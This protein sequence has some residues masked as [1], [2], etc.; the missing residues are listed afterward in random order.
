VGRRQPEVP[1]RSPRR[2]D[3]AA[4]L[5]HTDVAVKEGRTGLLCFVAV[6]HIVDVD[7]RV[8]VAERQDIV[9]RGLDS[10]APN[11]E[12]PASETGQHQRR[13]EPSAFLLFRYSALTFNSRRI[14]YDRRYVTEV[15]GYPGLIVH[16]PL[17]STLLMNFATKVGGRPPTRFAFRSLSPLFDDQ[18]FLLNATRTAISKAMDSA[19][20]GIHRYGRR[21]RMGVTDRLDF[22]APLF[23]PGQPPRTL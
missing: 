18:P 4:H 2:A 6:E 20:E 12:A 17:Q 21:S 13:I 5:A 7:E 8:L 19:R 1:R 16:G 23:V 22:V 9:Y 14:H 15:E 11:R 3:C 10:R